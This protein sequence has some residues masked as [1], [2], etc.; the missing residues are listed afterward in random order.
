MTESD[1]ARDIKEWIDEVVSR[2]ETERKQRFFKEVYVSTHYGSKLVFLLNLE[3]GPHLLCRP[4]L[5]T[6]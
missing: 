2:G 3:I 4:D 5:C 1:L 6:V